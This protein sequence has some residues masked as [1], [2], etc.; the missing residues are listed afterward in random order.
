MLSG[1]ISQACSVTI[2]NHP[3][4]QPLMFHSSCSTKESFINT[5]PYLFKP[6]FIPNDFFVIFILILIVSASRSCS[7]LITFLLTSLT[8]LI[9]PTWS[10]NLL[11]CPGTA[12]LHRCGPAPLRRR[13]YNVNFR[14]F[15]ITFLH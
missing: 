13:V 1:L 10:L 14:L 5:Y 8:F 4:G 3:L 6:I 2:K 12:E 15:L 7:Y 11:S 9:L